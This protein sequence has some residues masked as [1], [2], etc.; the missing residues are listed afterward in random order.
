MDQFRKKYLFLC[1]IFCSLK[2]L[3]Y[4]CLRHIDDQSSA[5]LPTT[6]TLAHSPLRRLRPVVSRDS[7]L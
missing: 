3:N 5:S 7:Q 6:S 2:T 1:V 4:L